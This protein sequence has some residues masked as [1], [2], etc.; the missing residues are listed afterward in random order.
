MKLSK[1]ICALITAMLIACIL[2]GC[3]SETPENGGVRQ[4]A[5]AK[6]ITDS[7]QEAVLTADLSGGYSVA[8]ASGAA[9]FYKGE[10]TDSNDPVAF[11]YVIDRD[12]YDK[13]IEY[14]TNPDNAIEGEVR[15]LGDGVYSYDGTFFF[16]SEDGFCIKVAVQSKGLAD[17]DT[18]YPRF[19][20][21]K[22]E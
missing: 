16:P 4:T 20:A 2:T 15:K 21:E 22:P 14:L 18:I 13:E 9:Y 17:A 5:S 6:Q 11:A 7:G 8:F 19:S 1:T 12:A 3:G 10:A